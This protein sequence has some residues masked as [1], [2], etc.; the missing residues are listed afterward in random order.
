MALTGVDVN[1]AKGPVDWGRV[2]QAGFDFVIL[3][4]TEGRTFDDERFA[5]HR[6]A[7]KAA[8]LAVGAYHFARPDNNTPQQEAAHFLRIYRP[9][10]GDL[11][12]ALD[13]ETDPPTGSWA[14]A[15]LRAVEQAIGTP[16]MLYTFPDFLRRTGN[17]GALAR[18]PLWYSAFGPNDGNVHQASPPSQFRFVIHQFSSR[19]R[20][21]G[22]NGDADV[23][24]L[25]LGSLDSILFQGT[26]EV[27]GEPGEPVEPV[28]PD[29]EA[30]DAPP[31]SP[32]GAGAAGSWAE[33][34]DREALE[35]E[36]FE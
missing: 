1:G 30:D 9:Q 8:G 29:P 25:K 17:F 24:V 32:E 13:W 3:K 21:S 5:A 26:K 11:L 15:F 19:G 35:R 27:P 2:R 14:L 18:F 28:E 31:P 33:K 16:P 22:V 34:G 12:P 10:Q 36:E 4:A 20:V 23:N 7:A 6:R